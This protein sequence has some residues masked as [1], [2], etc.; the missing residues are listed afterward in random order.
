MGFSAQ[1]DPLEQIGGGHVRR[2]VASMPSAVVVTHQDVVFHGESHERSHELEGTRDA[3]AAYLVRGAPGDVRT[4]ELYPASIRSERARDEIEQRR[5][6]RAI[7]T[8]DPQHVALAHGE[9]HTVDGT[10]SAERFRHVR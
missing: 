7:W 10:D 4:V 3:L 2:R 1:A 8:H 5:L 9:A 6:A